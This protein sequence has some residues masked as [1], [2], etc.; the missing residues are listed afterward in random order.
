ME[1]RIITSLFRNSP[2][3]TMAVGGPRFTLITVGA[4]SGPRR[5]SIV[6]TYVEM[7]G[8]MPHS[9]SWA[10]AL[11][12]RGWLTALAGG[13]GFV[14]FDS[15]DNDRAALAALYRRGEMAARDAGLKTLSAAQFAAT[16]DG[17]IGSPAQLAFGLIEVS[18][19]I[20]AAGQA[21]GAAFSAGPSDIACTFD[22]TACR[23]RLVQSGIPVPRL[24]PVGGG[25]E[26]LA[27]AMA[28]ARMPRVFVKLR[29]GSAAAGM[30]ALARNGSDWMASTTAMIDDDG[31]LYATRAIRRIRDRH[32]IA[33]I[34][35]R[36]APL[37]LHVEQWV[38]KVGI[39]NR[40]VDLRLVV[41]G[42]TRVF[43]IVRSSSHPMTNLHIGGARSP[44]DALAA[45]MGDVAWQALL[46][47]ARRT[48]RQF[49]SALSVGIDMAVLADGRRHVVLE[50]NAFGDH[51]R[52]FSI[53]GQTVH[54]AQ[55]AHIAAIMATRHVSRGNEAA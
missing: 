40:I 23:E 53:D 3:E 41:I 52:D 51:I 1:N 22:K 26:A 46:D 50:V 33:Q 36:L 49:P 11:D 21:F 5:D 55:I 28:D 45:S 42:G 18:R 12:E 15:P 25:F 19:E 2:G 14:R 34:I 27:I 44:A 24:L 10:D 29:H 48:A 8:R 32:L 6:D 7:T 30:V 37:G 54:Q 38:P 31:R 17:D 47:T 43:P 35:D 16:P 4:A 13:N 39:E 9:L 20:T